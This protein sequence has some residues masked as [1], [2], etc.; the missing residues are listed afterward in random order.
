ME[1]LSPSKEHILSEINNQEDKKIYDDYYEYLQTLEIKKLEEMY[2]KLLNNNNECLDAENCIIIHNNLHSY[3]LEFV[4][5]LSVLERKN[6]KITE[7]LFKLL[8]P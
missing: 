4:S 2:E 7:Y 1:Y 5:L 8:I 3:Q 6:I